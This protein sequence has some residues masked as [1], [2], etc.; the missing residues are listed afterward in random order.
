MAI[1]RIKKWGNSLAIRLS[2]SLLAQLNLHTNE[3][4]EII[5]ENGRF[6][7]S[8]V[9]RSLYSLDELLSHCPPECLH[10]EIGFGKPV[11]KEIW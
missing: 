7:I 1:T 2:Q 10:G 6:I 9:R 8:P 3:Q 4:V 11:G 5:L